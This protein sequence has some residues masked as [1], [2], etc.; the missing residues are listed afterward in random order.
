MACDAE[1]TRTGETRTAEVAHVHREMR[2]LRVYR[3]GEGRTVEARA[4]VL[5]RL[6]RATARAGAS[7]VGRETAWALIRDVGV[8]CRRR[9]SWR[10]FIR[11]FAWYR[12]KTLR[13]LREPRAS[14]RSPARPVRRQTTRDGHPRH[15][16]KAPAHQAHGGLRHRGR[17]GRRRRR[18]DRRRPRDGVR[19][20]SRRAGRRGVPFAGVHHPAL[21]RDPPIRELAGV[22]RRRAIRGRHS[23]GAYAPA[24]SQP[25]DTRGVCKNPFKNQPRS[26]TS[27]P[28]SSPRRAPSLTSPPRLPA[29]TSTRRSPRSCTTCAWAASRHR[30]PRLRPR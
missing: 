24:L 23:R 19:R 11:C 7:W 6:P 17:R 2:R 29:P 20:W 16:R 5:A 10:L 21:R 26:Q 18:I 25:L 15:A 12:N 14:A 27:R 30:S 13:V 4:R 3:A 9:R 8:V 1:R 22:R 28:A